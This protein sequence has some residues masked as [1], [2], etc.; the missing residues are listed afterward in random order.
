M[1][2]A[3]CEILH[4]LILCI[5]Q[6]PLTEEEQAAEDAAQAAKDDEEIKVALAVD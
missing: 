6:V 4:R 1:F 3:E 5:P 2:C